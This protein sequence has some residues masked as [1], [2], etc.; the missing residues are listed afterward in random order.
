MKHSHLTT[1]R[2]TGIGAARHC[3]LGGRNYLDEQVVEWEEGGALTMRI[4]GTNLPFARADIRFVLEAR[5]GTTVVTVTPD[6]RLKY[7]VLGSLLDVIY[8]RRTYRKGMDALLQGL[9]RHVEGGY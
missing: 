8:V 5:N 4:V 1:D 9:K 7:G 3:D 6:Y 2:A